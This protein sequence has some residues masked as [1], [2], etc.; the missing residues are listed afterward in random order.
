MT[1]I[2][3]SGPPDWPS[4]WQLPSA[5]AWASQVDWHKADV[6]D[7]NTYSDKLSNASAVV[8]SMG[9]LIEEDYKGV[10]TGKEPII[11]GL[12]K[13]FS[14]GERD[15]KKEKQLTYEAMNRDSAIIL[16]KTAVEKNVPTFLYISAAAGA[17]V[18][19]ARYL[20]TKRETESVL[21]TLASSPEQQPREWRTVF[22]RPAML[23]DST[24]P[25][26]IPLAAIAGV[27]SAVNSLVGGW[28]PGLG[29]AAYKPLKVAAVADA[30]VQ[31]IGDE[32]VKGVLDVADISRLAEKAWRA[33][34]L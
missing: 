27:T 32:G 19:P 12:K 29:A 28:L 34:M 31:A 10:L 18:L 21:P 33:G 13:A 16:A 7:P 5:P 25:I 8:H 22:L 4:L 30:V 20:S 3:R 1:S 23:Y 6:F 17:P 11:S 9:I 24:R 14:S 26:S 2:S 15:K